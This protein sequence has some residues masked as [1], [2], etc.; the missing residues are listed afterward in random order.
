[1]NIPAKPGMIRKLVWNA[2]KGTGPEVDKI[3]GPIL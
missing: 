1:M 3:K 2:G